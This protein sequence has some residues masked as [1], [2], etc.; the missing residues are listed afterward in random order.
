[1]IYRLKFIPF[2]LGCLLLQACAKENYLST[3]PLASGGYLARARVSS[4]GNS[5]GAATARVKEDASAFCR[6]EGRNAVIKEIKTSLDANFSLEMAEAE[7]DCVPI[8]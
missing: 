1:M 2:L 6:R 7:F 3:E 4:W 5:K 8:R